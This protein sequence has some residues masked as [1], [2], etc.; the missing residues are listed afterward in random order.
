[1]TSNL[2]SD[3]IQELSEAGADEEEIEKRVRD[4][5]KHHFRPEFL[6]R[7]DETVIFHRLSREDLADI[8]EIQLGYLQERLSGRNMEVRITDAAKEQLAAD[9][10]DP[11]YGA[12]PLKRLIQRQIENALAKRILAGEFA[13]GD[14]IEI[15]AAGEGYAFRKAEPVLEGEVVA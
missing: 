13:E 8:V 1:M 12:R 10:Y 14:C 5:L 7:V 6:N 3:R 11:I 15:D 9:G 2:G 4:V